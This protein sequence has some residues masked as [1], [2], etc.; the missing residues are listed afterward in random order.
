[1]R[2]TS[3]GAIAVAKQLGLRVDSATG[4]RSS[5]YV[6]VLK[7]IETAVTLSCVRWRVDVYRVLWMLVTVVGQK[8]VS[9]EHQHLVD[10]PTFEIL[11]INA[12]DIDR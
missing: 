4:T 2:S 1:M 12:L 5:D 9:P 8:Q 11:A 7:M 10:S 6:V 3:G